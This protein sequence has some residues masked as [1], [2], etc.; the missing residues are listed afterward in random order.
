[1]RK[2]LFGAI[3]RDV[4]PAKLVQQLIA[5]TEYLI[6]FVFIYLLNGKQKVQLR[7]QQ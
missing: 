2:K 1:M 5:F 6:A 3:R 4:I 7:R